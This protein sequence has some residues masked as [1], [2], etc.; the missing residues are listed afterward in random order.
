MYI[1]LLVKYIVE[2]VCVY[3]LL[4]C[5]RISHT[6]P[7]LPPQRS[8]GHRDCQPIFQ[9][10]TLRSPEVA[11]FIGGWYR[12]EPG[13]WFPDEEVPPWRVN[14]GWGGHPGQNHRPLCSGGWRRPRGVR[15]GRMGCPQ[16]CPHA[17]SANCRATAPG[18]VGGG[19]VHSV[20]HSQIGRCGSSAVPRRCTAGGLRASLFFREEYLTAITTKSWGHC[21]PVTSLG[22]RESNIVQ[23]H[24]DWRKVR[25][26]VLKRGK[27][28]CSPRC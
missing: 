12:W 24:R 20:P 19:G 21:N 18:R 26:W 9:M 27:A 3:S 10:E 22:G 11:W 25:G 16:R 8:W 2:P 13:D 28:I 4:H 1:Y 5:Q 14:H 15:C 7:H 23:S 17:G 6:G